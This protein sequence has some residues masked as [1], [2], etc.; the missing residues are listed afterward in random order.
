MRAP[1]YLIRRLP[2]GNVDLHR[3]ERGFDLQTVPP[4]IDAGGFGTYVGMTTIAQY[5]LADFFGE[6]DESEL[7]ARILAPQTMLSALLSRFQVRS[8][9][10]LVSQ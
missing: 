2:G 8:S 1:F 4:V 10:L 5:V 9:A 6:E 3:S 7:K